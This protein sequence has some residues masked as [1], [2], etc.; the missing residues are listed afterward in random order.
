M[1]D[2]VGLPGGHF[3]KRAVAVGRGHGM[4]AGRLARHDVALVVA[5]VDAMG[6]VG[7]RLP[8]GVQQGGGVGLGICR[9]VAADGDHALG[10]QAQVLDDRQGEVFHFVGDDAPA[11]AVLF[12]DAQQLGHAREEAGEHGH[13][14]FIVL[15]ELAP[16][17]F[18]FWMVGQHVEAGSQQPA[19]ALRG[20]G[21]QGLVGQGL[22][23][24]AAALLVGRRRKVGG[25]VRQGAVE[26]E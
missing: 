11:I 24:L 26:I 25:G 4:H 5:D 20:H 14:G 13:F 6:R 18:V 21:A 16:A 17:C 2:G 8:R 23:P 19:R 9:G 3:G 10:V 7:S 22:Q 15:Q 12:Q 1:G